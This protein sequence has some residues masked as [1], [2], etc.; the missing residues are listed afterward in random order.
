M[1]DTFALDLSKFIA[2]AN[3]NVEQVVQKVGADI[4]RSVVERTPV[5]DPSRWKSKPPKGYVGG[6]LRANWNVSF[7]SP[8]TSTTKLTD[9]SGGSTV[10][11][12]TSVIVTWKGEADIYVMNSLPYVRPIEYD[13]HSGQAPAGMVRVTV[14]DFQGFINQ[15]VAGLPR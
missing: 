3:G 12:G 8:D 13:G 1:A 14:A 6:R 7:G 5:G 15:A 2:K 10:A 4:L 9:A 11:R